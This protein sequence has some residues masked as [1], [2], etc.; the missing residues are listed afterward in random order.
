MEIEQILIHQP[1]KFFIEGDKKSQK[2]KINF[3]RSDHRLG[4]DHK[5]MVIIIVIKKTSFALTFITFLRA[6]MHNKSN[7]ATE[8]SL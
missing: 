2:S 4:M 3:H 7:N 5:F 1:N 8:N 6:E